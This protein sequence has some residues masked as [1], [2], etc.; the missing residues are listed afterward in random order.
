MP[1]TIKQI[2][3][4]N[5]WK[6]GPQVMVAVADFGDGNM[7]EIPIPCR[8]NSNYD[9]SDVEKEVAKGMETLANALLSYAVSSKGPARHFE[10]H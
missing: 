10:H 4:G 8:V 5:P 1:V 6:R 3:Y 9:F 2:S 7:V